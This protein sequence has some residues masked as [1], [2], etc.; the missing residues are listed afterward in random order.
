MTITTNFPMMRPYAG[1][2]FQD[3]S[4]IPGQGRVNQLG[5][6]FINGRPLPNSVRHQIIMMSHQNIR[7]C[8]ISR[9]LRVSH[10]CVSKILNRYQ[11]T[12]SIRPGVIGGS[13]PRTAT[14]E[15][16]SR[17]EEYKRENPRIFHW[18]VRDRLIKEGMCDRTTLPSA[19]VISRLIRGKDCEDDATAKLADGKTSES[20][21]E[22]EPGVVLKRKQRRSRTTF[23][24]QQLDELE[25]AFERTHYPDIYTREELAQR[26]KL[27]ENRIQV[28]FSNRRARL[29]KQSSSASSSG[30]YGSVPY[31]SA[32]AATSYVLHPSASGHSHAATAAAAAASLPA[33]SHSMHLQSLGQT[34]SET[35][36][37]SGQDLYGSSHHTA[38]PHQLAAAM[39]ESNRLP[40]A[41]PPSPKYETKYEIPASYPPTTLFPPVTTVPISHHVTHHQVSPPVTV[42]STTYQQPGHHQ[43]PPTPN[44]LVTMMG[45]N[46]G[47][48]N[49]PTDQLTPSEL[50]IGSVSPIHHPGQ[51]IHAQGQQQG[52]QGNQDNES[53]PSWNLPIPSGSRVGLPPTPPTSLPQTQTHASGNHHQGFGHY[54]TSGFQQSARPTPTHQ[55][56][57]GWY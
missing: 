3:L 6:I 35:A 16:A 41:I 44:S 26:T 30:Y 21:A 42:P 48:S 50:S 12:G 54:T 17:I 2:P 14:P 27:T 18:D 57:Y 53:T 32:T 15:I 22:S 33:P 4:S 40:S 1:Y 37:T 55:P 25:R 9:K 5:G 46:S 13:K 10:G 23:T 52:V 56:F 29:R 8:E 7:P 24:A 34:I 43:L 31:P 45:P 20:D 11:E 19:S 36:F 38:I 28:W 51:H 47:S 39:A 49:P